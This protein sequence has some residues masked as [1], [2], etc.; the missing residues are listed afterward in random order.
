MTVHVDELHTELVPAA[1]APAGGPER[2]KGVLG[3]A[4]EQW[5]DARCDV[6]RLARRVAAEG[7][8][9]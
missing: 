7:F 4:A 6:E 2:G 9:D 1:T 3:A 5:E 8:D